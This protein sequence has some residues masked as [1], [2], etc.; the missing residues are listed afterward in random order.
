MQEP[1][2]KFYESWITK[3]IITLLII[4]SFIVAATEAQM[5][6]P[7]GSATAQIFERFEIAFTVVFALEL[8]VNMAGHW[9]WSFFQDGW[10]IL[11]I[12]V[13]LDLTI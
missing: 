6:P 2:A 3:S 1:L 5:L 4:A 11:D 10:N 12:T 9:S 7:K 8:L 13:R